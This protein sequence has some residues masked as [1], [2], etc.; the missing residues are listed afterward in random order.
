MEM[1]GF[2]LHKKVTVRWDKGSE[3]GG[4]SGDLQTPEDRMRDD[5]N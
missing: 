5:A 2:Y 1:A 4:P 3:E